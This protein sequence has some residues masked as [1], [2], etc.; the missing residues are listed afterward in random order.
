MKDLQFLV[1]LQKVLADGKTPPP[2]LL[3]IC[4]RVT[5]REHGILQARRERL[6]RRVKLSR[7]GVEG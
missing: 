5:Q 3:A 2:D 7:G 6:A 4:W 1:L